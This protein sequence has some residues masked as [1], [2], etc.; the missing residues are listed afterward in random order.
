MRDTTRFSTRPGGNPSQG[1][2]ASRK[3]FS[4]YAWHEGTL[5]PTSPYSTASR[6]AAPRTSRAGGRLFTRRVVASLTH[7]CACM[8]VGCS[9]VGSGA[10]RLLL[11]TSAFQQSAADAV[12]EGFRTLNYAASSFQKAEVRAQPQLW[13]FG[14]HSPVGPYSISRTDRHALWLMR[15]RAS[16]SCRTPTSS[17]SSALD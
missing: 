6:A 1:S 9:M 8:H 3:C 2:S 13:S 16:S 4:R 5:F 11:M 7:P 15:R 14:Q 10:L 17:A 12:L